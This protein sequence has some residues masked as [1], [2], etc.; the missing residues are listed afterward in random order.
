M[1][2]DLESHIIIKSVG[3]LQQ[4]ENTF[5]N[6]YCAIMRVIYVY[7]YFN[8]MRIKIYWANLVTELSLDVVYTNIYPSNLKK[9]CFQNKIK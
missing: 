4:I 1:I 2:N 6:E 3:V 8:S 7:N 9:I 5:L